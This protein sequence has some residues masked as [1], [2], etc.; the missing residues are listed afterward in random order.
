MFN[1]LFESKYLCLSDE[2]NLLAKVSLVNY[3]LRSLGLPCVIGKEIVRSGLSDETLEK[4]LLETIDIWM[5]WEEPILEI[6]E[7]DC[8]A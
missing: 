3:F 1:S 5:N 7:E 6:E 2:C 8:Y 4:D